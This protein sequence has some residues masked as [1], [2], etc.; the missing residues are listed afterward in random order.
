[1]KQWKEERKS[2][3]YGVGRQREN[4]KRLKEIERRFEE[5]L[6][7]EVAFVCVGEVFSFFLVL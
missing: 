5:K 6:K 3:E 1:L 2:E 4:S 7:R